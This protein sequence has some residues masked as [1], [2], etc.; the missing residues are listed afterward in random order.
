[1][2]RDG[3]A[4]LRKDFPVKFIFMRSGADFTWAVHFLSWKKYLDKSIASVYHFGIQIVQY[5][6]E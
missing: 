5:K 3:V 2:R 1:M 4:S 6:E